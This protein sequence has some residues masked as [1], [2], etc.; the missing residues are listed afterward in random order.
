M[1]DYLLGLT[2][3]NGSVRA[4]AA[5]TREISER[6]R[7]IH[8]LTPV[9]TAA[10]GRLMTITLIMG[11]MLK[12]D[13]IV[14]CRITGDG[15]LAG[16][17][18]T[19]NPRGAV[20]GYAYNPY[21]D[22]PLNGQGKFDVSGAIGKGFLTVSMDLGLKEPYQ[23]QIPLVSGEIAE[24]FAQYYLTSEQTPSAVALGVLVDRDRTVKQSGGM[25]IQ[26]MPG[27]PEETAELLSVRLEKMPAFTTLLDSG[28]TIE[29]ILV[30]VFDGFDP[31]LS[32]KKPA[33]FECGCNRDKLYGVVAALGRKELEDILEN[34]KK[35]VLKCHFCNSEYLFTEEELRI[36]LENA[37]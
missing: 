10:L 8:D 19:S 9:A 33:R 15:P 13:E 24:D 12:G 4:Y 23:G 26:L 1:K 27:C 25:L 17:I 36:I 11:G 34:E 7:E 3:G 37:K 6:A 2:A 30:E 32:P 16:I 29:Q 5:N 31:V 35:A 20:K 18:A 28:K 14:T 22:L 21:A